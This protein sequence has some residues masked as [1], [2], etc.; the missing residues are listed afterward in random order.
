MKEHPYNPYTRAMGHQEY[1]K[2]C[3][4]CG[5]E[6]MYHRES[7]HQHWRWIGNDLEAIVE[8]NGVIY[9]KCRCGRYTPTRLKPMSSFMPL[10]TAIR[11]GLL[12]EKEK[13]RGIGIIS[14]DIE[15]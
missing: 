13:F 4:N 10:D 1:G 15:T 2:M 8:I 12:H 3:T 5:S 7:G 9:L 6:L 14:K 11:R